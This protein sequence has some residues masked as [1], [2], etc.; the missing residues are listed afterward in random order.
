MPQFPYKENRLVRPSPPS[1]PMT[2]PHISSTSGGNG[3]L[4]SLFSF[5]ATTPDRSTAISTI[6]HFLCS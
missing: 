2:S 4:S 5:Q 6:L 1:K 3:V